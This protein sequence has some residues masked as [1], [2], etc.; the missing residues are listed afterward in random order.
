MRPLVCG[1]CNLCCTNK[2]ISI[3]EEEASRLEHTRQGK[4]WILKS[5]EDG[6][7]Y[8]YDLATRRCSNYANRPLVCREFDCREQ[9]GKPGMPPAMRL[10]ALERL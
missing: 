10:A 6:L 2:T 5:Q 1:S 8:Y 9:T 4:A 7:C 3:T